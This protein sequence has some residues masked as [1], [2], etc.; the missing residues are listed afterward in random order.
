MDGLEEEVDGRGWD[1]EETHESCDEG[2]RMAPAVDPGAETGIKAVVSIYR[3]VFVRRIC[4]M[5]TSCREF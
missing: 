1:L 4:E 5:H 3:G 2:I